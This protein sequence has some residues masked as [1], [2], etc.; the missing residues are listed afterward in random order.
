MGA[1]YVVNAPF[2][3]SACWSVV[4][5]FLDERTVAKIKILGGSYQKTL[6]EVIDAENLPAFLGGKC[7][8]ADRGG[9]AKSYA[10]PW[11]DY[12]RVEPFGIKPKGAIEAAVEVEESKEQ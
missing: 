1:M 3:F 9:C 11:E 2:V 8:C 7:T 12:E 4:K 6:L 10:G 5:G